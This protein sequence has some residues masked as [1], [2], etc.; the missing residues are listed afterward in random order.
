[1]RLIYVLAGPA[2][3]VAS[4]LLAV[5]LLLASGGA[6]RL[7]LGTLLFFSPT[8][9][10]WS[11]APHTTKS[12]HATDGLLALRAWRDLRTPAIIAADGSTAAPFFREFE[13]TR[14]RWTVLATDPNGPLRDAHLLKLLAVAPRALRFTDR[15]PEQSRALLTVAQ[16][17]WCWRQVEHADSDRLRPDIDTALARASLF[18]PEPPGRVWRA[19]LEL[20]S[21]K[22]NLG[23]A[24]PGRT[25]RERTAFLARATS[26]YTEKLGVA[27][28]VTLEQK[29]FAFRYGVALHDVQ[30]AERG[31]GG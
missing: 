17:G 16:A 26:T 2:A 24:S 9:A 20:L 10:V 14:G 25:D 8:A 1:M 31:A 13:A 22:V 4:G 28:G 30:R 27:D 21:M 6:F 29:T 11:L 5:P 18:D 7:L 23:L 15:Q 12:G 3:N 19:A